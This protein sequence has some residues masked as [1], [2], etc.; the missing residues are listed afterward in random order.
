MAEEFEDRLKA[1]AE[2]VKAQ[3]Q[4]A[5]DEQA[6]RVR[7]QQAR[8]AIV[9]SAIQDWNGR[10]APFV[11]QAVAQTN[12]L[13]REAGIQIVSS[14]AQS[15]V[16]Q[17][18]RVGP[19]I[20]NLPGLNITRQ[21]SSAQV[22]RP[23]QRSIARA[24]AQRIQPQAELAQFQKAARLQF[25]INES[26]ELAVSSYNYATPTVPRKAALTSEFDEKTIKDAIAE[27]VS[28]GLLGVPPQASSAPALGPVEPIR[29]PQNA[30]VPVSPTPVAGTAPAEITATP[31]AAFYAADLVV[32]AET[33][34]RGLA[35]NTIENRRAAQALLEATQA[36]IAELRDK[37]LNDPDTGE[38]IDFL[39][40]LAMGL[41][42]LV[43]NL[44]RAIADPASEPMFLGTAGEIARQLKLGLMEAVEKNRVRI[45]EVGACVGTASFLSWLSGESL[46]QLLSTL[47]GAK[48]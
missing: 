48:K 22:R 13:M 42:E 17:T 18:N 2:R 25:S 10:I 39:D 35:A 28:A 41:S 4:K 32:G 34:R 27:F 40:W 3:R 24:Q 19:P 14:P 31:V 26:G 47:F 44:D 45:W 16:R 12:E 43:E 37:R 23:A 15:H 5:A 30:T 8:V 38:M 9:N 36:A 20:P 7:D 29:P 1:A 46:A 6:A 21:S 11:V 33:Y